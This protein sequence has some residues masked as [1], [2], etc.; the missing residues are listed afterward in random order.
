MEYAN[1]GM[2]LIK[3]K[4][5]SLL[6]FTVLILLTFQGF[7]QDASIRKKEFLLDKGTAI[8]GYD[9][10]AYFSGKAQKG[11][12]EFSYT[13]EGV[14]Y[15]FANANNLETFKKN[16]SKYEPQYGGWCAYAMGSKGEKVDVDPETFKVVNGKLYLFYHTFFSNTLTDWNKDENAL[17]TKA[18]ANWTNNLSKH[19]KK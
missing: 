10:T 8:S 7:S 15:L 2:L 6:N 12:K 1:F 18:D 9:P 4:M 19:I 11:K 17:K 14:N 5:K 13:Q 3:Q 16:P